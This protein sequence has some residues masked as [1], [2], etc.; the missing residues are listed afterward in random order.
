MRHSAAHVLAAA[1]LEL[2]P[3]AKFGVGP[4]IENGFYYD[5]ELP[6]KLNPQDLLK[7]EKR[8]REIIKRNE[9]FV[10]EEMP[11][12]D[13]IAFFKKANQPYKVDL[14]QSLKKKGS[15][16][17]DAEESLDIEQGA[18]TAS[19]YRTGKFVD[20]CRGPHVKTS[21]EIG[22]IKLS[23]LSGA[24]WRGDENNTQLQRIYGTAFA[25]EKELT[26]FLT[27]IE[28]AEKRDHRKLGKDLELFTVINEIGPG[29]PLFYPKGALLRRFVENY[30]IEEQEKRG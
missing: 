9:E 10:R 22:A 18:K 20:L 7:I 17:I 4:V 3:Q 15:T 8:M 30:I 1:V 11:L 16:A 25:T 13:A 5:M 26:D 29:L 12:D 27:M 28:E 23:S 21:K 14:L 6:I 19:V 2:Y 24:Y